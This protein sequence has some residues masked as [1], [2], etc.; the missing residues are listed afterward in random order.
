M[1]TSHEI[2]NQGKFENNSHHHDTMK[3]IAEA[4]LTKQELCFI[5]KCSVKSQ[6]LILSK[7]CYNHPKKLLTHLKFI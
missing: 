2:S 5:F 3:T 6:S 7:L 1:F 4:Y